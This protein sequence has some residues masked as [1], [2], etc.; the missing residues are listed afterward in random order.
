MQTQACTGVG[1]FVLLNHT[2]TLNPQVDVSYQQDTLCT[3]TLKQLWYSCI[4]ET[5]CSH[6]HAV[7]PYSPAQDHT[8]LYF[9]VSIILYVFIF[10][11]NIYNPCIS[12]VFF[13]VKV[14][15]FLL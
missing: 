1:Q 2:P 6:M 14:L 8:V 11:S 10:R 13:C 3:Q 15:N 4:C 5:L 7:A 9:I 12:H